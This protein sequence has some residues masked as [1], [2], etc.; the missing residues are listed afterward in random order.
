MCL[1]LTSWRPSLYNIA[2]DFYDP[3]FSM[4][5]SGGAHSRSPYL[6]PFI[7]IGS[8]DNKV[9]AGLDKEY[10]RWETQGAGWRCA[11]RR[12]QNV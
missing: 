6:A 1:R 2:N 10:G 7:I 12:R 9:L 11:M 5:R 8:T 3:R 4:L